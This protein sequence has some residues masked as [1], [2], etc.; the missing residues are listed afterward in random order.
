M[1]AAIAL[2]VSS[3]A[4]AVQGRE[5]VMHVFREY[6]ALNADLVR[7]VSTGTG[8]NGKPYSEL[9]RETEAYAEGPFAQALVKVQGLLCASND[10][11][12][13]ASLLHVVVATSNSAN[14]APTEALVQVAKCQP[15]HLKAIAPSL[16]P[17]Q[18]TELARRAPELE[19]VF[20]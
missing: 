6:E 16:P 14:E 10:R 13:L 12:L 15:V 5:E 11:K 7:S 18:R 3:P 8:K 17:Q 2:L 1:L 19:A 20:K 4:Q 9:R